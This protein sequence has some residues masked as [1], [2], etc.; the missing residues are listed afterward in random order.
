MFAA[1]K[2]SW[3]HSIAG[4]SATMTQSQIEFPDLGATISAL[5][6]DYAGA[7]GANPTISCFDELWGYRSERSRRLWDEMVPPPTRKIAC[8][9]TTTYAGLGLGRQQ[10]RL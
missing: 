7:A 9:L 5:A 6:S 2:R 3:P 8:R 10:F 1:V 4:P